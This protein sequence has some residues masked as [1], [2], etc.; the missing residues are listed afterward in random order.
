MSEHEQDV[1]VDEVNDYVPRWFAI[2]EV[3]R[4]LGVS[5][6]TIRAWE[7]SPGLP[8]EARP[9]RDAVGRRLWSWSALEELLAWQAARA[10]WRG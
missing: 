5:P 2:S 3:A 6:G 4:E 10:R 8:E 9:V 7:R 1:V